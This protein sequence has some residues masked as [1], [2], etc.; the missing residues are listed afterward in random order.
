MPRTKTP[1]TALAHAVK[2]LA[3]RERTEANLRAALGRKSYDPDEIDEALRTLKARGYLDDA[4]FAETKAREG[5]RQGRALGD[6]TQRLARA[7]V[8]DAVAERTVGQVAAQAG[9]D[10]KQAALALLAKRKLGGP[11][12]ARFLA[13]RGFDEAL[14]RELVALDD[15]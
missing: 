5:L 11:K 4:R 14:I 9:Y 10:P 15:G 13:S 2:L 3:V 1:L 7:G 8:D 6:L 12:A